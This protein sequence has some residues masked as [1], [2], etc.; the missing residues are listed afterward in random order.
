[1]KSENIKSY[2]SQIIQPLVGLS[3]FLIFFVSIAFG[4]ESNGSLT[5]SPPNPVPGQTVTV[6]LNYCTEDQYVPTA[7]FLAVNNNGVPA[8]ESCAVGTA[9]QCFLVDSNGINSNCTDT[10]MGTGGA[11]V[12]YL[13]NPYEGNQTTCVNV[14]HTYYYT[15][16]ADTYGV[17]YCFTALVGPDGIYCGNPPSGSITVE[18]CVTVPQATSSTGSAIKTVDGE[19]NNSAGAAPGDDILFTVNYDFDHT[20]ANTITDAI[21]ANTTLVSAGPGVYVTSTAGPVI[22][23]IPGSGV[24]QTGQ[25]WMLVQVNAGTPTGTVISNQATI[26]PGGDCVH[27]EYRQGHGEW[28]GVQPAKDPIGRRT[29][30]WP[31]GNLYPQLQ[32]QRRKPEM[33]RW[34]Q[35]WSGW[36]VR[37]RYYWFG[38]GN[39][40]LYLRHLHMPHTGWSHRSRGA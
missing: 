35:L 7:I 34:G 20:T 29:G 10:G 2:L 27:D 5:I 3:L 6:S 18:N 17:T 26:Q 12:G 4:Q 23:T 32:Y 16:P 8:I 13:V 14:T 33:V 37:W 22:W 30:A 25:V 11:Q 1:M 36:R 24:N 21:P 9:G 19:M 40:Q 15:L 31:N 28:R 38:R 39:L